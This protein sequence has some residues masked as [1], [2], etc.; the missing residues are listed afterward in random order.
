M[1]KDFFEELRKI[2]KDSSFLEKNVYKKVIER[3]EKLLIQTILEKTKGN[4]I[5]AAEILGINRNTLRT[6][7]KKLDINLKEYKSKK[8]P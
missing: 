8:A 3:I 6:K 7:I 5:K 4:Q 1:E 2:V